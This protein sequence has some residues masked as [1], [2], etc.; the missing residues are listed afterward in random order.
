MPEAGYLAL[1]SDLLAPGRLTLTLL[2]EAHVLGRLV[3]YG[4]PYLSPSAPD[5]CVGGQPGV[6]PFTARGA[7]RTWG[8]AA[9]ALRA[10]A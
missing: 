5:G 6:M 1:T 7:G 4:R 3:H 9:F 10:A 2:P 8:C